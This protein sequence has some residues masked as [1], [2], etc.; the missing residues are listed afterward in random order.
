VRR[1]PRPHRPYVGGVRD[2]ELPAAPLTPLPP[3]PAARLWRAA[4]LLVANPAPHRRKVG[5]GGN[6]GQGGLR[7]N[8]HKENPSPC[9]QHQP[10]LQSYRQGASAMPVIAWGR[11]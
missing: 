5:G 4:A 10:M 3:S 1:I 6:P 7:L 9:S 2:W 8:S 11:K